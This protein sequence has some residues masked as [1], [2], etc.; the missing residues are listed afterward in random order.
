MARS[1]LTAKQSELQKKQKAH[2]ATLEKIRRLQEQA[3]TEAADIQKV[4][5][6][7]TALRQAEHEKQL[8]NMVF[9]SGYNGDTFEAIMPNLALLFNPKTQAQALAALE[10]V[11]GKVIPNENTNASDISEEQEG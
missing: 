11:R 9:G 1:T 6:E 5:E 8:T 3:D 7:I 10:A 2:E 4:E